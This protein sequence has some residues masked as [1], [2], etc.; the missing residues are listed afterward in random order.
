MKKTLLKP[1]HGIILFALELAIFIFVCAPLQLRFGMTGLAVTEI[2][3]ILISVIPVIITKNSVKEVFPVKKPSAGQIFAVIPFYISGF[4]LNIL[5]IWCITYFFPDEML[6][7][8]QGMTVLFASVPAILSFIIVA[9]MPAVCE[10]VLHRG[11]IQHS[12]GSIRNKWVLVTVMGLIFGIFHL[13]PVRFLSTAILGA[14]LSY[15]MYE[16]KNIILPALF[17]LLNNT[18]SLLPTL[19]PSEETGEAVSVYISK[20][21]FL[22]V[23]GVYTVISAGIPWL[24][25]L[26]SKL[27]HNKEYNAGIKKS[28]RK[29]V[30]VSAII[31]PLLFVS[32][33]A[34]T[35]AGGMAILNSEAVT[36]FTGGFSAAESGEHKHSFTVTESGVYDMSI[37]MKTQGFITDARISGSENEYVYQKAA[38]YFTDRS[39]LNLSEGEYTLVL[40]FIKDK[41][42]IEPYFESMGYTD[43]LK[44]QESMDEIYKAYDNSPE[45]YDYTLTF[46][47]K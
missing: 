12:M 3:F 7:T 33:L 47:V 6:Q 28:R 30:I 34:V 15:I 40:T 23:L 1:C 16:T 31:S 25:L 32:G 45:N 37:D 24:F 2:I 18:V 44:N 41:S 10:E 22:S 9:V 36:S 46:T 19:F 43:L 35:T 27:L 17:H 8:E 5:I 4:I 39:K 26:G 29:A 14:I 13:D 20:G 21:D 42:E 11:F 38:E